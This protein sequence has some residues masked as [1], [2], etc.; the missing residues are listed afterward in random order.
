MP[1]SEAVISVYQAMSF[2]GQ[3]AG[4]FVTLL[5]V[6]VLGGIAWHEWQSRRA[7]WSSFLLMARIMMS[8]VFLILVPAQ[9][10]VVGHHLL[11]ITIIWLVFDPRVG[12]ARSG[13]FE[14]NAGVLLPMLALLAGLLY[15]LLPALFTALA[16]SGPPPLTAWV[17]NFGELMVV[18]SVYAWWWVHG[19]VR[20]TWIWVAAAI[21]ALL[22]TMAF[23]QN[24]AM[25]GILAIWSTG[26]SL[27]LHW[28]MYAVALW[29]MGVTV[30]ATWR[31]KPLVANALLLFTAAGYAP[32]M[33]PQLF[34][35]L[36]AFWLLARYRHVPITA[37]GGLHPQMKRALA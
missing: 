2:S 11:T 22:F 14:V 28:S 34:G 13:G 27:Y 33:S 9:W 37:I 24:P 6:G 12:S 21:P 5:A 35:A 20:S 29:L 3:V 31:S 25:T 23:F 7:Y 4:T 15:Q 17:F 19:R 8:L 1:K 36:I 26:L 30:L 32:Q 18:L 10:I 16:A